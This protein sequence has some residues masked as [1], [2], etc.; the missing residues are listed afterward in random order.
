MTNRPSP[1]SV[2]LA[3][4]VVATAAPALTLL[5]GAVGGDVV[6]QENGTEV[7]VGQQLAVTVSTESDTVRSDIDR[8]SYETAFD[9]ATGEDRVDILAAWNAALVDRAERIQAEYRTASAAY[10]AGELD[11]STYAIRLAVLNTRAENVVGSVQAYRQRTRTVSALMLREA[12]VNGSELRSAVRGL[13]TVRG[14][15]ARAVLQRF[16]GERTGT[17]D[18]EADE[19]GVSISVESENG[20]RSRE[21]ERDPDDDDAITVSQPTALSTAR[22]ALSGAPD[23][24]TVVTLSVD[25]SDGLYEF[26]FTR[27][28]GEAEVSV[29]GSSG[30]V[31][32][33]EEELSGDDGGD[34]DDANEKPLSLVITEGTPAPGETVTVRTLTGGDPA[35]DALVSVNGDPVGRTAADGTLTVQLPPSGDVE[36]AAQRG[37]SEAE[38]EIAD[39]ERET[40]DVLQGLSVTATRSD[41]VTTVTVE[42]EGDPVRNARVSLDGDSVGRTDESGT[43]SV[44]FD[45][46]EPTDLTVTKGEFEAEYVYDPADGTV[47]P[48]DA[49]DDSDSEREDE[50]EDD[51]DDSDGESEDDSDDS[52]GESGDDGDDSDG[53][54]ED[55]GDDSDGESED[56][57]DDSDGE[58]EDGDDSD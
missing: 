15:G 23:S 33:L 28:D 6:G 8:T 3:V 13:E 11:E 41:G 26:E 55:D 12:G 9:R 21:I 24:W 20:E 2:V 34:E 25:R 35:A 48:E 54:S 39:G 37:D 38:L 42:Y 17:V 22:A 44:Q 51:G 14:T 10:R 29:D 45:T 31:V 57:G 47:V 32:E 5:S 56:D 40:D 49:Y 19:R 50:S 53:E 52:D 46:T 36:I 7:G 43:V 4:L 30:T 18:I 58:S 1:L 16:T 27:S